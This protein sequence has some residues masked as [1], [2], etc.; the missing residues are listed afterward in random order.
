MNNE[1]DTQNSFRIIIKGHL[2][3]E[4]QTWLDDVDITTEGNTTLL[5]GT[6]MD[7]AELFGLLRKINGLGLHLI[8][9]YARIPD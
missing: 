6:I 3:N 5:S 4:W 8:E 7:Q 9:L 1:Q 2:D